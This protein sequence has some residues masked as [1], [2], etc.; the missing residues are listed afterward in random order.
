M[1]KLLY[2]EVMLC[3][4]I[5]IILFAVFA[6]FVLIPSWPPAVAFVY[7]LSGL[8][9][10]FPRGLANKDIEYTSLLPVRKTDIVK[11]KML[12]LCLI[13]IVVIILATI[14][15]IIRFFFFKEPTKPD[16]LQYFMAVRPSISLLGFAF[17]SFGIMNAVLVG[18]YYR[19]PYKRLAGPNLISLL[20]CVIILAIG[21]VVIAFAPALREYDVIGIIAQASTLVIGAGLFV[22]F[23]YL[24][25]KL[26]AKAFINVDL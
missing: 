10:L 14:G 15:G 18:L 13:E 25:Y 11:G 24:G 17:L 23:S 9:S 5:Q 8:M 19:N 2:K 21:S 6:L 22:L 3:T 16:E 20:I 12:Y 7:P 26:G 4:N 1:K